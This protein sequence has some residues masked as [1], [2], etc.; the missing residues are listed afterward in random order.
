MGQVAQKTFCAECGTPLWGSHLN[1]RGE[2]FYCSADFERLSPEERAANDELARQLRH[3]KLMF[4]G[5]SSTFFDELVT[6]SGF[7]SSSSWAAES[8]VSVTGSEAVWTNA[9][10]GTALTQTDVVTAGVDYKTIMIVSSH[11]DASIRIELGGVNGA[12]RS[13]TGTFIQNIRAGVNSNLILRSTGASANLSVSSISIK[14][15]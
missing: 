1:Q 2:L 14:R 11:T 15:L 6:D 3:H 8:D 13:S 9:L 4:D 5:S 10:N 7:D 12:S